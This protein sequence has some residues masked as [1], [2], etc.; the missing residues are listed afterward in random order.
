MFLPLSNRTEVINL[1]ETFLDQ[2]LT[3]I[4]VLIIS[5]SHGRALDPKKMYKTKNVEVKILE[6][7]KRNLSG[8]LALLNL[9]TQWGNKPSS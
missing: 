7:G 9:R 2:P 1:D 4:D 8:A 3:N 6:K 5:D